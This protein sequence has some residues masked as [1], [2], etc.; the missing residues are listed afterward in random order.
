MKAR[1]RKLKSIG[2]GPTRLK[3]FERGGHFIGWFGVECYA[4]YINRLW[5]VQMPLVVAFIKSQ[6]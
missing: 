4:C 3:L 6:K 2:E 5:P 1:R